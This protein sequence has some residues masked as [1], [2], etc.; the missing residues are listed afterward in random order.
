MLRGRD[1][2]DPR[3]HPHLYQRGGGHLAGVPDVSGTRPERQLEGPSTIETPPPGDV[4]PVDSSASPRFQCRSSSSA[5]CL[6]R[7]SRRAASGTSRGVAGRASTAC[8]RADG[9][10][11]H[12]VPD[13]HDR[14][15]LD[16]VLVAR[17]PSRPAARVAG[18][19]GVAAVRE[20]LATLPPLVFAGEARALLAS[21]GEVCEGGRSCSRQE[22]ASSRSET[23]LRR[24]SVS[25]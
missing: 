12:S 18:R 1:R 10:R 4:P 23:S 14:I 20:R 6:P 7:C 11:L 5:G 21:L 13:G 9:S 25:G 16:T 3:G 8:W 17:A 19:G 15:D 22:T 24:R 2:R